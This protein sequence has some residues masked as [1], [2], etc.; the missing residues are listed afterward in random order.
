M[1]VQNDRILKEIGLTNPRDCLGYRLIVK[2]VER[3]ADHASKIAQGVLMIK[4]LLPES[5]LTKIKTQNDFA[6]AL[7]EESG[8]ALFKR[9]YQAADKLVERTKLIV[10]MQN[11]VLATMEKSKPIDWYPAVRLI[12][13]DIRRIAEYSSDIDEMI[14][15]MTADKVISATTGHG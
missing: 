12:V 3:V 14:L 9:D 4:N 2:S 5:I 6:L 11:D 7:F 10:E 1:A 13:E 15:N 8:L